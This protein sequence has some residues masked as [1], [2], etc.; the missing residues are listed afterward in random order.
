LQA[1][2][3]AA[4]L[5]FLEIV[6][7]RREGAYMFGVVVV[8]AGVAVFFALLLLRPHRT[9]IYEYEQGLKYSRGRFKKVLDTG[10]HWYLGFFSTIERVDIRPRFVTITGQEVLSSDGVTLKVSLAAQ[11][12]IKDGHLAV[13]GLGTPYEA[14]FYLILQLALREIVGA[15]KIDELLEKRSTLGSQ[16]ME[17][18]T[19]KI[20]EIGLRLIHA[21][22]KDIM[23]PG[24]LKRIFSQVAKARQ[25]GLAMLERARGETA[26][27]RNLANSANMIKNN[28]LLMQLRLL[29]STGNTLV[30]P[31]APATSS[32][33]PVPTDKKEIEAEEGKE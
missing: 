5:G 18:A 3:S 33:I 9:T 17:K 15:I 7:F 14:A 32:T 19:G 31:M 12:E 25:E 20:E 27:L 28:P 29:H 2:T 24:E 16:I 10:I 30:I 4:D 1:K 6:S 11:Y 8:I 13:K 23:F 26:A 22:V 21:E